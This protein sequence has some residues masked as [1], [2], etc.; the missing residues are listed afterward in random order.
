VTFVSG[1]HCFDGLVLCADSEEGDG[2]NKRYVDKLIQRV[3][4][5]EWGLCFGGAGDATAI[6]K[7]NEKLSDILQVGIN[8]RQEIELTTEK[9]LEHMGTLYPDPAMRFEILLGQ[10]NFSSQDTF[11]FRAYEGSYALR[12]IKCGEFQCIGM[13]TSLAHFFLS[14]TFD[15]M[16]GIKEAMRLGIIAT[17]LMKQHAQGVGGPTSVYTFKK[18][19]WEWTRHYAAEIS[20]IE[21]SFPIS[22]LHRLILRHWQKKNSDIY[23]I[24]NDLPIRDGN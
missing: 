19:E 14:Q 18:G 10:C 7:F 11:L 9:V 4:P 24:I 5:V 12:P 2:V 3:V 21:D 8:N 6:E 1:F 16:T 13:D 23:K 17:E 15:Y 20:P 22:D